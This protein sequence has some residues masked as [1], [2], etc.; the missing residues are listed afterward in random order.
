MVIGVSSKD[1]VSKLRGKRG[2]ILFEEFGSFPK[3]IDIYNVVR[4]G[5]EEGEYVFGQAILVG[6][7]GDA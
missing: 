4:Y 3:L 5:L 1:N 6:T 7:A 2:Y